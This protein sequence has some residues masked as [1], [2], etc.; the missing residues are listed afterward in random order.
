VR[1]YWTRQLGLVSSNVTPL[2]LDN[3]ND[4]VKIKVCQIVHDLDG[5]LL[6]DEIIY[7]FF[8]MEDE[9]IARFEIGKKH[10]GE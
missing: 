2:Q 3:E 1:R 7:H 4:V 9:K 6:A 8:Y 10:F 5:N